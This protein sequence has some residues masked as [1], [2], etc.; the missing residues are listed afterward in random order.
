MNEDELEQLC[1]RWFRNN[2]WDITYGPD[3]APDPN[4][5]KRA[6]LS[7]ESCCLARFALV[8]VVI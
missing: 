7:Q 3:I 4:N 8:Q 1:P 6:I 5:P 2:S